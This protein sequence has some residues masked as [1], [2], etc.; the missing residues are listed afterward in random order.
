MSKPVTWRGIDIEFPEDRMDLPVNAVKAVE[1]GNMITFLAEVVGPE[2]W[3]RIAAL[4]LKLRDLKELD[5]LVGER[6][7]VSAGESS[8]SEASS[9]STTEPS[10]PTSAGSME[11]ASNV[12]YAR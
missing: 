2:A 7:G 1:D 12:S 9:V 5:D 6:Y 4:N 8:G 11:S 10:T 3:A